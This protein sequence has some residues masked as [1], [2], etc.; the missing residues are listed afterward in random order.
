[1]TKRLGLCEAPLRQAAALTMGTRKSKKVEAAPATAAETGGGEA[2]ITEGAVGAPVAVAPEN[3]AAVGV[4]GTPRV[5]DGTAEVEEEQR[6][7]QAPAVELPGSE[8]G[9]NAPT[10]T[11]TQDATLGPVRAALRFLAVTFTQHLCRVSPVSARTDEAWTVGLVLSHTTHLCRPCAQR[12]AQPQ[13][14]ELGG[15]VVP[16]E[17]NL[18]PAFR[19]SHLPDGTTVDEVR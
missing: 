13:E 8:G 19:L 10:H 17:C 4:D 15:G 18:T 2:A 12:C 1:M 16:P 11:A 9:G 14:W 5:D 6:V 7:E 3:A